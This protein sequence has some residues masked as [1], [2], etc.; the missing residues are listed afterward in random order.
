MDAQDIGEN[1]HE[2]YCPIKEGT[3]PSFRD[4]R[5]VI[6]HYE[7]LDHRS[8]NVCAACSGSDP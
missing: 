3:M 5:L 8:G 6:E 4:I 7:T 2:D 1:G